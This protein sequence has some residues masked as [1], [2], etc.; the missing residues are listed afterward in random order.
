MSVVRL[1]EGVPEE[2][3]MQYYMQDRG[4]D[5]LVEL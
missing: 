2:D 5:V 4:R 3:L 1:L